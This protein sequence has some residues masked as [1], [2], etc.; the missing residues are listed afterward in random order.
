ML[1][2]GL[3]HVYEAAEEISFCTP[4]LFMILST[5]SQ[6]LRILKREVK[7]ENNS[8]IINAIYH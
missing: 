5:G 6:I 2:N 7:L 8:I 4:P 3:G 1:K